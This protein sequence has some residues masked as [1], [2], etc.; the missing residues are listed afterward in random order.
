MGVH[1]RMRW[2]VLLLCSAWA[3]ASL[4]PD[5]PRS[6][7]YVPGQAAPSF[8][9]FLDGLERPLTIFCFNASDPFSRSMLVADFSVREFVNTTDRLGDEPGTMV[10]TAADEV[11]Q[12]YLKDALEKLSAVAKD[13]LPMQRF[14]R[15]QKRIHT[16]SLS[17]ETNQ[18]SS[19]LAQWPTAINTMTVSIGPT[20]MSTQRLDCFYGWCPWPADPPQQV[21]LTADV[22]DGCSNL[23]GLV[24][25][26]SWSL[27]TISGRSSCTYESAAAAAAAAGAPG[28]VLVTQPGSALVPAG[29][30]NSIDAMGIP[31]TMISS[32]AAA[33]ISNA[34]AG[35]GLQSV[36]ALLGYEIPQLGFYA[37][38]DTDELLQSV[39][40]QK[41]PYL[42]TLVWE[43]QWL[44]YQADIR[45]R[46]SQPAFV[47]PLSGSRGSSVPSWMPWNAT[48]DFPASLV[49][50]V[51]GTE[52]APVSMEIDMQL[53]CA[54]NHDKDCSVWDHCVV[55]TAHCQHHNSLNNEPGGGRFELGR[56]VTPFKRRVGRWLTPATELMPLLFGSHKSG[57][58]CSFHMEVGGEA[59]RAAVSLRFIPHSIPTS[60]Y[61]GAPS[62]GIPLTF[63]NTQTNFDSPAYNNNRTVT[64]SVPSAATRVAIEAV[65]TGHGNC[66]FLPPSHHY[67]I[68]SSGCHNDSAK[69]EKKEVRSH[70]HGTYSSSDIAFDRYMQAGTPLGCAYLVSKG[71]VPNE[72]GTWMYGRNGWC[73]GQ[74]V[75]PLVW[76]V[77]ESFMAARALQDDDCNSASVAETSITVT[78]HALS[79]DVGGS[80]PTNA[81]C[82]GYILLSNN[83]VW[84]T[85]ANDSSKRP[86]HFAT[87]M[88]GHQTGHAHVRRAVRL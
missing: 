3:G 80:N 49:A 86:R 11:S 19:V 20:T 75:K 58:T 52:S 47:V 21:A 83:L 60:K 59:W 30:N 76:D 37:A 41:Q 34:A 4:P 27:V 12:S 17:S 88:S 78:Y 82:G 24:S 70:L 1:E 38:V 66:E 54:G 16:I 15:F 85:T 77:T 10:F 33:A 69:Q 35:A 87:E 61:W 31:V 81:G 73:D 50:A 48:V 43:L 42:S 45:R 71:S 56:W 74:D 40:W 9:K 68:R 28:V 8:G 72:H 39:G 51:Y 62:D 63:P 64:V 53:T 84:W 18:L 6:N 44:N 2:L 7:I 29:V 32:T 57:S 36:T 65:I 5:L 13:L 25:R 26:T 23:T 79:Y 46:T 67:E 55:L 22:L 14:D